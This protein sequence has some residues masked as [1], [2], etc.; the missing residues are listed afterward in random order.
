MRTSTPMQPPGPPTRRTYVVRA[1]ASERTG[2]LVGPL[3]LP[4][5]LLGYATSK[6]CHICSAMTLRFLAELAPAIRQAAEAAG[7]SV[8]TFVA[9]AARRSAMLD[10]AQQFADLGL[11]GSYRGR[12][13]SAAARHRDR[14]QGATRRGGDR[15]V[16]PSPGSTLRRRCGRSPGTLRS[17]RSRPLPKGSLAVGVPLGEGH[18][19]SGVVLLAGLEETAPRDQPSP[20]R[21]HRRAMI[22]ALVAGVAGVA[23]SAPPGT[24]ARDVVSAA[25]RGRRPAQS[26][27]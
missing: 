23:R 21:R 27:Q 12:G 8:N 9:R 17:R 25:G 5:A 6:W 24:G 10:T 14:L 18:A 15:V 22:E 20:I 2:Q 11:G 1:L 16:R 7:L 19:G 3:V 4:A 26:W 13:E